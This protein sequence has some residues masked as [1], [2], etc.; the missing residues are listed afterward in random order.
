MSCF[1]WQETQNVSNVQKRQGIRELTF[2]N[3]C[4][5][6]ARV[7]PH[8]SFHLSFEAERGP[9]MYDSPSV[10]SSWDMQE[11]FMVREAS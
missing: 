7:P 8:S 1:Y 10:V 9:K 3:T 11:I 4:H 2:A 5:V 6:H